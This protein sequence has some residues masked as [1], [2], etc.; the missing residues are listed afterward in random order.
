MLDPF[1]KCHLKHFVLASVLCDELADLR[2][3][4]E[5]SPNR[6]DLAPS[7]D[8]KDDLDHWGRLLRLNSHSGAL[9][10]RRARASLA[11]GSRGCSPPIDREA[12]AVPAEQ[13][14]YASRGPGEPR[15]G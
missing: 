13:Q 8:N 10:W 2:E 11:R 9:A 3:V 5:A 4:I 6:R 7:V 12:G 15:T 1:V 14:G